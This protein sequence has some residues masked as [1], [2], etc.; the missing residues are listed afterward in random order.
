ME[1]WIIPSPKKP[2]KSKEAFRRE[3]EVKVSWLIRE[4]Y[5]KSK[6]IQ[7]AMLKVPREDFIPFLYKDYAYLGVPLPLPGQRATIS[8]PHS[9]PLFYEPLDLDEGH[10]FLEVGLGS[11]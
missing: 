8:C 11:G 3:R 5:L 9:Y 6:G 2:T 10:K 1:G 7:D 4:G